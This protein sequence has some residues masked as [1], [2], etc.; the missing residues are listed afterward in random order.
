MGERVR[1]PVEE[2]LAEDKP[3]LQSVESVEVEVDDIFIGCAGFEDRAA[4]VILKRLSSSVRRAVVVD[5]RPVILSNRL[6]EM[7]SHCQERGIPH[8]VLRYNRQDPA[9]FG[10]VLATA[11]RGCTGRILMDISG[12]SRLLIVQSL[13]ALAD[14]RELSSKVTVLYC[15]AA[16]YPPSRTAVESVDLNESPNG[17]QVNPTVMLSS[18]V[19]DVIAVPELSSVALGGQPIRLIAFPSFN[20]DQLIALIS[21]IQSSAVT[22]VHGL[23]PRDSNAW[24]TSAIRRINRVDDLQLEQELYCNT[25]NYLDTLTRLLELYAEFGGFQ[26]LIVSP[27]G[28]KMQSVAVGLFRALVRDVQI[29]Y[30]TPREFVLPKEYTRGVK[31]LFSLCLGDLLS[32]ALRA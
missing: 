11:C 5:Y 2:I 14:V 4:E 3:I 21:E 18:G 27:T 22:L 30:P 25:L 7:T 9:G 1:K 16:E 24:R 32:R 29:V 8:Q 20:T 19:F 10:E 26:R 23:P 15:E 6:E 31:Q 12:M 28:S 17:F 13:V